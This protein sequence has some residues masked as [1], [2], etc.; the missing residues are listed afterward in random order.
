MANDRSQ[1]QPVSFKERFQPFPQLGSIDELIFLSERYEIPAEDVMLIALNCS[2]VKS[3]TKDYDRGRFVTTLPDGQK[4]KLALT[5]TDEPLSDFEHDGESLLFNGV[6]VAEVS[7]IEEDT[8][9]DSYWRK[10][11]SHLTLNSNS[12][13]N[14]KGC[15]FCGTYNLKEDDVPLNTTQALEARASELSLDLESG[16]FS[17]VDSIGLVTGCFPSEQALVDHIEMV[18][19]AFS[20]HGF[21]GELQY[22]G[23]QL[24]SPEQI[25]RVLDM[26]DF[27]YYLTLEMFQRR[28]Q[29][30][31]KTK[32]SL[33][34]EDAIDLL[35]TAKSLGADT[36]FLYIAGLDNLDGMEKGFRSMD[37]VLTRM[38]S[39]QTFQ[40]YLPEQIALRDPSANKLD[41][42]LE[43]R[44]LA[45]GVFPELIPDI[46]LNYR[47]LW[48]SSFRDSKLNGSV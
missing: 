12:R 46:K 33:Q 37:G 18:R 27:S 30:M 10:G 5:I 14:C 22:I 8:C 25:K 32:A 17:E 40:V 36:T 1:E 43:T 42:Y 38:P 7:P 21:S 31:K 24:R 29:L 6:P 28:E 2:G 9:T 20:Q 34:V 48:F 4:F 3:R 41:Y 15:K 47:G 44:K 26:G 45:E 39:I 23:S 11:H 16:S 19:E 35:G 13:S